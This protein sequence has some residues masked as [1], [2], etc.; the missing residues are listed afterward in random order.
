MNKV[1]RFLLHYQAAK[2]KLNVIPGQFTF[3]PE[4]AMNAH[5]QALLLQAAEERAES[6]FESSVEQQ[7]TRSKVLNILGRDSF[8]HLRLAHMMRLVVPNPFQIY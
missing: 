6:N 2:K 3:E 7:V 5:L 8:S 1:N 4:P